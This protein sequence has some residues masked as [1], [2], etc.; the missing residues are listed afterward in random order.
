MVLLQVGLQHIYSTNSIV[1]LVVTVAIAFETA[2]FEV[3][4]QNAAV[5][6]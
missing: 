3:C 2:V 5:V 4:R 1:A 6:Q